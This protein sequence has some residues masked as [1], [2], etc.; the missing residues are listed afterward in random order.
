MTS[1]TFNDSLGEDAGSHEPRPSTFGRRNVLAGTAALGATA[2]LAACGNSSSGTSSASTA[3][4]AA[5]DSATSSA[6]TSAATTGSTSSGA[7]ALAATS[8]IPVGGGKIFADQ[9][10]VVT[11]PAAGTFKGF[12]AVC[13]HQ[14][15]AVGSVSGGEIICPCHNSHFSVTDGSVKSGPASSALPSVTLK[16]SGTSITL[17]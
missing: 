2:A 6:P 5:T 10:V 13:T 7:N 15:C 16:V 8:D 14:G 17:G 9:K 3:T 11:Q 4:S 12:S 1:S